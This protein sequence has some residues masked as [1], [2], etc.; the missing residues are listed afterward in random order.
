MPSE[1]MSP[2]SSSS[3]SPSTQ[4]VSISLESALYTAVKQLQSGRMSVTELDTSVKEKASKFNASTAGYEET[5]K[6]ELDRLSASLSASA[7]T[8]ESKARA[9][10][11]RADAL[12]KSTLPSSDVSADLRSQAK[13]LSNELLHLQKQ[14]IVD[15][16]ELRRIAALADQRLCT[17]GDFADMTER[18]FEHSPWEVDHVG[19]SIVVL[20]S[21]V[22]S[23]IRE[24]ETN[25]DCMKEDKEWVAPTSFER[26]TTKYW[27]SDENLYEV[28]LSSVQDLPLLV[29]GKKGG[30]ILNQ[31][32]VRSTDSSLANSSLWTSFVTSISSVYF[33]SEC[34]SMYSERLKRSE[35][36]QLFRIRWYG[37]KP[38]GEK[39]VFLEL[40]T[41]H[42]KWIG[43]KSVKERCAIQEKDVPQLLDIDNSVWDETRAYGIVQK[44][45]PTESEES[46]Q[47]LAK[48]LLKMRAT[49]V[50]FKLTAC[51]RTKYTR[52]ALQSSSS[53]ACRLTFDR[54]LMVINERGA[55]PS[56]TKSWCLEDHDTLSHLDVVKVPY[57]VYEVKIAGEDGKPN[58]VTELEDSQAIVEAKKFSKFLSGASIFNTDKVS[59]LPWWSDE[60]KFAPIYNASSSS[61]N[62]EGSLTAPSLIQVQTPSRFCEPS[63]CSTTDDSDTLSI[64]V[65]KPLMNQ[66][67]PTTVSSLPTTVSNVGQSDTNRRGS[68]ISIRRRS[69]IFFKKEDDSVPSKPKPIASKQRLRVEPKSHFA[70]ERTFIQWISAALLFITFSQLL[71]ILGASNPNITQQASIAGTWMIAM[72]LFIAVY[73]LVIYYR[74]VYLMQN[75]K[76][77]GYTDFFGPGLLTFAVISGVALILAFSGEIQFRSASTMTP[78]SGQC[79]K[80]SLSGV[81]VMEM[82]PSGALVD[83]KEGMLLVPSLNHIVAFESDLSSANKGAHIVA[84]VAGANME[85]LEQVGKYIYAL[86]E[87][88][89][90]K[91]E[92]IA[93][94]WLHSSPDGTF[95]SASSILQESHRWKISLTG[96]EGMA[97][98]P[99][100]QLGEGSKAKLLVAGILTEPT[101]TGLAEVLSI[102]AFDQDSFDF[103][104]TKLDNTSK[105]NKKLVS[106]GLQDEK[107]GSMQF[108]EG[109][110]YVLFDNA[111]V[112]RVFDPHTGQIDQEISLPT[113][114]IG[115]EEEWEGMRLQRINNGGAGLR[116]SNESSSVVLHL[117]L[118]TPA[119]VWSLRLQ[120]EGGQWILPTCAGV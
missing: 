15:T 21:D 28:L 113:A 29:Y 95:D 49:I 72:S 56:S 45:N 119:Q 25:S 22:Y 7:H 92:I 23:A 51:V 39:N 12:A 109:R 66:S 96:A 110:L 43:D 114:E 1:T 20:L 31:K 63:S 101:K 69:S 81:P 60:E 118:D 30:R 3:P 14:I 116:G 103:D 82:Q 6:A 85:A 47:K 79:V 13:H 93:L 104:Q 36:A 46:I 107:V 44:A 76:P 90:K 102:D 105:I 65:R 35:G 78:V 112:I 86:S 97:L 42:E 94:K 17:G 57:N 4:V 117:A 108:F 41:H 9:L 32:E 89:D 59:T 80:R 26:V 83:E 74:R 68:W 54:D 5:Y 16:Q 99:E 18:R 48:L 67:S 53:N 98:V 27:V 58:F 106:K 64:S 8:I 11:L 100:G 71:Y 73:A 19:G 115:A 75:G 91:S 38:R 34:M 33:D 88:T 2:P 37:S 24:V 40:K 111:R 87:V 61:D 70:N 10:L 52:V 77:Y 62:A 84:T 55:A 120:K 50:R